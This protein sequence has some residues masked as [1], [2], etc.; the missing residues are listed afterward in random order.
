MQILRIVSLLYFWPFVERELKK[1]EVSYTKFPTTAAQP[2][3]AY[4]KTTTEIQ[5]IHICYF[6]FACDTHYWNFSHVAEMMRT[7]KRSWNKW[8]AQD[9]LCTLNT[10]P[11]ITIIL[12]TTRNNLLLCLHCQIFYLLRTRIKEYSL[13][14][15]TSSFLQDLFRL[16]ILSSAREVED[17]KLK[18]RCAKQMIEKLKPPR[19]NE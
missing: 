18:G 13:K 2:S 17:S 9:G 4:R 14:F 10:I 16:L 5:C 11:Y 15:L 6:S 12:S 8:N 19:G 1:I 7:T 3:S